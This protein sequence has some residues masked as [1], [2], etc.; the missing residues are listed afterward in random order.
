MVEDGTICMGGHVTRQ[1][2][3]NTDLQFGEHTTLTSVIVDQSVK[4]RLFAETR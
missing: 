3:H 4:Q 1:C 2:V